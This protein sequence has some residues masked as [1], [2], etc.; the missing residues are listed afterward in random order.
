MVQWEFKTRLRQLLLL[1]CWLALLTSVFAGQPKCISCECCSPPT[2]PT[3]TRMD[4]GKSC[5]C[6][7][8]VEAQPS[9][10]QDKTPAT[11]PTCKENGQCRCNDR[12]NESKT[13]PL[14]EKTDISV[15]ALH[16]T[17]G[18]VGIGLDPDAAMALRKAPDP[19]PVAT[20][21]LSSIILLI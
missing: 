12:P 9:C 3:Q 19:P 21:L 6:A 16:Y 13:V 18:C 20:G 7:P 15:T 17:A 2:S 4:E 1:A 14:V 5:C 11:G 10:C 8:V